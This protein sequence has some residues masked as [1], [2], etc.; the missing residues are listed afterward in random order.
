MWPE[1]LVVGSHNP[2]KIR[3]WRSLLHGR[4]ETLLDAPSLDLP[5][6][7]EP[8]P[9]FFDNALGKALAYAESSGHPT[10]AEDAGLC[11]HALADEPGVTTKRHATLHGGWDEAARHLLR[12]VGRDASPA[13]YVCAVAVAW[14]DGRWVCVGGEARGHLVAPRGEGPGHTPSFRPQGEERTWAELGEA[15][16]AAHDHRAEAFAFLCDKL[17]EP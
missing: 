17:D 15:W 14:P 4:V 11:V 3:E 6:P 8:S 5:E 9:S 10:L 7:L 16:R 1:V 13:T 2:G 12:Q